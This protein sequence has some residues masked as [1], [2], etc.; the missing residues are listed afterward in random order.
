M[1]GSADERESTAPLV[2]NGGY[3]VGPSKEANTIHAIS[4]RGKISRGSH[5]RTLSGVASLGA[6]TGRLCWI[7]R[8]KRTGS[9]L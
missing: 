7:A 1:T 5:Y 8:T 2:I 9:M 4:Q 3:F 6:D